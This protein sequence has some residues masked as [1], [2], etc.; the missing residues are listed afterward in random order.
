DG[1][2]RLPHREPHGPRSRVVLRR[3]CRRRLLTRATPPSR[4]GGGARGTE[5]GAV[6]GPRRGPS[7]APPRPTG[8]EEPSASTRL[9]G[10]L[11]APFPRHRWLAGRAARHPARRPLAG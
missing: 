1:G 3:G 11:D 2:P 7:P 4:L 10:R 5:R 6:I 9:N 8:G